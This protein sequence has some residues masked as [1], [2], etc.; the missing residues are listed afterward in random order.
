VWCALC[1]V[2][3]ESYL[4][5]VSGTHGSGPCI[6]R[7]T[8]SSEVPALEALTDSWRM[9]VLKMSSVCS[10]LLKYFWAASEGA[11]DSHVNARR[12]RYC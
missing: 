1:G 12:G 4:H 11:C 3:C 8:L 5:A 9:Y 2:V 10:E 6:F 7:H